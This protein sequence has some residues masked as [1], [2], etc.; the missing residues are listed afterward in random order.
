M[1][2]KQELQKLIKLH[3]HQI[4]DT[5]GNEWEVLE[6]SDVQDSLN[7]AATEADIY[8]EIYDAFCESDNSF[9]F[10]SFLEERI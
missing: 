7:Q 4:T 6:V 5:S 1:S 8:Q 10:M 3:T 2:L 9:A